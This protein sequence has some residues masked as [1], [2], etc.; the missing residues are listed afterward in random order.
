MCLSLG[1]TNWP[2]VQTKLLIR[3]ANVHGGQVYNWQSCRCLSP[4]LNYSL[5]PNTI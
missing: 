4:V 5:G 2:N 1:E 3:L